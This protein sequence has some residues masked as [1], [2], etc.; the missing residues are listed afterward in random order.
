MFNV[1]AWIYNFWHS[2]NE[3]IEGKNT[4]KITGAV[5]RYT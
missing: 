2:P 5:E 1:G 3:S 4:V